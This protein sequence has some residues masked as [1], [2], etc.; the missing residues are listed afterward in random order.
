MNS[1][2]ILLVDDDDVDRMMIVRMLKS[3]DFESKIIEM[4]TAQSGLDAFRQ[5]KFDCVLLDY[6]LPG[7]NGSEVLQQMSNGSDPGKAIIMLTGQGN[8]NIAAHALKSG[9]KDYLAKGS[10][11]AGALQRAILN[12]IEKKPLWNTTW[13]CSARNSSKAIRSWNSLHMSCLTTCRSR[14]GLSRV[15]CNCWKSVTRESWTKRPINT[16]TSPWTA[17]NACRQ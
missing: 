5:G 14:Y 7:M 8:E 4:D 15:C 17:P 2:N 9:A 10:M 3:C 11:N 1:I 12:A 16:F 6:G 13:R